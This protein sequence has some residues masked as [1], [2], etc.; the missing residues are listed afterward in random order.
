MKVLS[1]FDFQ[2][3][4]LDRQRWPQKV[5][6]LVPQ[7]FPITTVFC[8]DTDSCIFQPEAF[9]LSSRLLSKKRYMGK[10]INDITVNSKTTYIKLNV[11]YFRIIG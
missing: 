3:T 6:D 10:A 9:Q 7:R 1:A 5:F 8:G 11:V 4:V 2:Y